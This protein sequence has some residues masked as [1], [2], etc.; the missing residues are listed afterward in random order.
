LP[1]ASGPAYGGVAGRRGAFR[2][3]DALVQAAQGRRRPPVGVAGQAHE[4]GDEQTAD[5]GGVQDDGDAGADAEQLDKAD[6][7]GAE[8]EER[9]RQ[10][11]RRGG[12]DAAGAAQAGGHRLDGAGAG[13]V[14]L[15]DTGQQEHL[16]VHGQ[17]EGDAEDQQDHRDVGRGGREAEQPGQVPV[18]EDPHQG[19]EDRGQRQRVQREGLDRQDDAAG[20]QEQQQ[21]GGQGDRQQCPG[22]AAAD[23][24]EGIDQ[25]GRGAADEHGGV[26]RCRECPDVADELLAGGGLGVGGPGHP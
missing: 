1:P 2:Q 9:D 18:L 6:L 17:P 12:D 5:D 11:G 13:V 14:G 16:V 3:P 8:G 23:G 26:A 25:R 21:E 7:S 24:S 22:Q 15:L 10:Q 19:A 4:R 20:E